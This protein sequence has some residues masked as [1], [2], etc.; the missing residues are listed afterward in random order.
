MRWFWTFYVWYARRESKGHVYGL[1]V[2]FEPV[3][4]EENGAGDARTATL[5]VWK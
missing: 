3:N 2:F 1:A 5:V 4:L